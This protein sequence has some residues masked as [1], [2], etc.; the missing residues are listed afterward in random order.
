VETRNAG[1]DTG[2]GN[3]QRRIGVA[4]DVPAEKVCYNRVEGK[5]DS[6]KV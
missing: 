2:C 4:A 1:Q 6:S 3:P 5:G